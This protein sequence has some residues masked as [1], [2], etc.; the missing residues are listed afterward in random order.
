MAEV[1]SQVPLWVRHTLQRLFLAGGI[2]TGPYFLG[3]DGR[4]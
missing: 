3:A 1:E 2:P 4:H